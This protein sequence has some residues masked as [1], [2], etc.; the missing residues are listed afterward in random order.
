MPI[1]KLWENRI[2]RLS[3][4]GAAIS[5]IAVGVWSVA[6]DLEIRPIL[7]SEF[8]LLQ[9]QANDAT[10]GINSLRFNRLQDLYLHKGINPQ[11]PEGLRLLNEMCELAKALHYELYT[12][13]GCH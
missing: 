5:S 4:I 11:T 8:R 3:V 10:Q 12:V 13:P 6:D 1:L 2:V 9:A 7:K